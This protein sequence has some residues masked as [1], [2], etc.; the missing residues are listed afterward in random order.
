MKLVSK[1]CRSVRRLHRR[2]ICAALALVWPLLLQAAEP[3]SATIANK[4]DDSELLEPSP[5]DWPLYNR[6]FDGQRYSP[7]SRIN[8]H[9][10]RRLSPA[11]LFQPGEV[12]FFQAAPV[13][14]AGI[15]YVTTAYRTFA[16]DATT[17]LLHW[18]HI[19]PSDVPVAA[20]Q[21]NRGV[22]IYRGKLFRATPDG[23]LLAL[24]LRTGTLLWDKSVADPSTGQGLTMAPVAFRGRVF[25][26]TAGGDLGAN[27]RIH[28][29]DVE[30]G[31]PLWTL[32][33]IA[34]A[35]RAGAETWKKGAEYGGGGMYSTFSL[36]P[37]EG[38]L[39]ASIGNPAPDFDGA[40]R[41]GANL[42]TNSV[43]AVDSA[44][45]KLAWYVQQ[46][47]HD[48][49]DWDTVAA[50]IVY[51]MDG[52]RYLAVAN[53]G[54]WLYIYDQR[55]RKL[56]AKS[57]VSPHVNV[58]APLTRTGVYHCPGMFGGVEWNGPAF[59]PT[60]QLL[61][62]NSVHLCGTT[63]LTEYRY[64]KGTLY[65]GGD[66]EPDQATQKGFTRAFDARTGKPVWMRESRRPMLAG[67]T[68][69]AGRVLFTGDLD[70]NF[71]VLDASTGEE[72]YR[73]NTGGGIA[74]G[75]A[76]YEVA[77]RQYVAVV[78]GNQSFGSFNSHGAATVVV[79]T[80]PKGAGQ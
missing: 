67:L 7:L 51:E 71:F 69:T 36:Q 60:L 18:E 21:G 13:V 55:T 65:F 77:G 68:P 66:H 56:L 50:P 34:T 16:I 12:G 35:D 38:L 43:I 52:R 3:L 80:L 9:N 17:C 30:T 24:D 14:F 23:H 32:A 53:K 63:R 45:G 72:L 20:V 49:H 57:E 31:A 62:V 37:D 73:F 76:T 48:I 54:G 70:G 10:A 74:G 19:F 42:Y 41:P 47:P 15:M 25:V 44:A 2:L 28:A 29:L 1:R 33:T 75:V 79:F 64:I 11:C 39:L 40:A 26:G 4:P 59:S 27:G 46:I 58:D 61:Y 6:T 8:R 5:A 22:A 78:S